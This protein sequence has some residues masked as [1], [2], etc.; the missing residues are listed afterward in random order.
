MSIRE[1]KFK[2][3]D[4]TGSDEKAVQCQSCGAVF[5]IDL[6]K[7]P[8]CGATNPAGAEKKYMNKLHGI[9]RDLHGL[10]RVTAEE[11]RRELRET[12]SVLKKALIAVLLILLAAIAFVKISDARRDRKTRENYFWESEVFQTLDEY[13]AQGDCDAIFEIYLEALEQNRPIYDWKHSGLLEVISIMKKA[14]ELLKTEEEKQLTVE[15]QDLLWCEV[16]LQWSAY[17]GLSEEEQVWIAD[18]IAPYMEDLAVRF[19]M[20]EEE[21]QIFENCAKT[22]GGYIELKLC[23]QYL[24]N[25]PADNGI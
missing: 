23:G 17:M 10:N 3:M 4:Q 20:S 13:Y 21:A 8:Y 18:R 9:R 24:D 15:L 25:H 14:D 11:T 12:G 7:C 22:H 6:P 16:S 5:D 2:T 19:P 1:R